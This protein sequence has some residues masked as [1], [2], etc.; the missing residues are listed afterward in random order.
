VFGGKDLLQQFNHLSITIFMYPRRLIRGGIAGAV[1]QTVE[2]QLFLSAEVTIRIASV[3]K[4][5]RG[6]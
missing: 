4:L 5:L 3:S 1:W 2:L 6:K